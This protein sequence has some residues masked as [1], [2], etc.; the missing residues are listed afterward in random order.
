LLPIGNGRRRR[1]DEDKTGPGA[2][3]R[4]R[5]V[6]REKAVAGMDGVRARELCGR[7]QGIDIQITVLCW[8]RPDADSLIGLPPMQ[9]IG[10]RIAVDRDRA[11]AE[12]SGRAD[13][14]AGDLAAI[15]DQDFAERDHDLKA[16]GER[17]CARKQIIPRSPA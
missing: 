5:G 2:G 13:D 14:A 17:K 16:L 9:R 3:L 1:T 7:Q 8:R 15:G 4:E 10:I 6:L 12:S 11:I